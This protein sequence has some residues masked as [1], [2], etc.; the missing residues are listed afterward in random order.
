MKI[1]GGGCV[2]QCKG[3]DPSIVFSGNCACGDVHGIKRG[4]CWYAPGQLGYRSAR[5]NCRNIQ[6]LVGPTQNSKDALKMYYKTQNKFTPMDKEM[7]RC[8][9]N[10][11]VHDCNND[12]GLGVR[13]TDGR[14]ISVEI[15]DINLL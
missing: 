1:K 5:A 2:G 11:N 14:I 12:E 10:N 9:N 7:Q 3:F 13:D 4:K 6:I 15:N 8:N